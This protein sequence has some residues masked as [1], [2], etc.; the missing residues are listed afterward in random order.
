MAE[1]RSDLAPNKARRS[2]GD[3]GVRKRADGRWEATVELPSAGKRLRKSVYGRTRAEALDKAKGYRGRAA[4]LGGA[5]PPERMTVRN[6]ADE[7]LLASAD[8]VK[9]T[10][11]LHYEGTIRRYITPQLG[12][13]RIAA[14]SAA[15]I[16][17]MH[18]ALSSDGLAPRTSHHVHAVLSAVLKLGVRRRYL[19][20]NAAQQT[21]PPRLAAKPPGYYSLGEARAIL[22]AARGT[23][24]EALFV[25]AITTGLRQGE[26]LG[27]RWVDVDITGRKLRVTHTLSKQRDHRFKLVEPKTAHSRRTIGL[28]AHAVEAL[29]RHSDRE[30]DHDRPKGW[31]PDGLVFVTTRGTHLNPANLLNR[32]YRPLLTKAGVPAA[33]FH[34]LRHTYATN[35]VAGGIPVHA[36]SRLLGHSDVATTMRFYAHATPELESDAVDQFERLLRA[37]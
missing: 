13:V 3:G 19:A 2:S 22:A 37:S 6:L 15:Q 18:D 30:H 27:L 17:A 10:T 35:A 12:N 11:Y 25:L 31:N 5:V 21:R 8:R 33:T 32:H 4:Q 29:Q 26:L 28:P 34:Q 7:F 23:E 9:D 16:D 20:Y 14:L 36:V 24:L 1:K